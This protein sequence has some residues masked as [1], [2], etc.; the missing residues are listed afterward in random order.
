MRVVFSP[1]IESDLESIADYIA[2]DNP[3]RAL[4]FIE[5]IKNKF[6]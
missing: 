5:E 3:S 6:P 1:K 2:L 4:T